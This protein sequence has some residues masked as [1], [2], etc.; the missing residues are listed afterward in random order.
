MIKII[1]TCSMNYFKTQNLFVKMIHF[2]SGE[3]V[4][5]EWHQNG[6]LP[7]ADRY[8]DPSVDQHESPIKRSTSVYAWFR[9]A[10]GLCYQRTWLWSRHFCQG[11]WI[12]PMG[13]GQ[14]LQDQPLSLQWRG[15]WYNWQVSK[16]YLKLPDIW[17]IYHKFL[18]SF[19]FLIK[20]FFSFLFS[21]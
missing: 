12:T 14:C 3:V 13:R 7:I 20:P 6:H 19:L 4:R 17:E 11:S 16:I 2:F 10:R 8:Q 9:Q 5:N 15:S 18:I 21:L 1:L